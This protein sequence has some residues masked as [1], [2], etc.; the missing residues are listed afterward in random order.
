MFSMFTEDIVSIIAPAYNHEE[1]II[2]SLS[3]IAQQTYFNKQLIVIDDCSSDKTAELI[4]QYIDRDVVR[5]LFPAGIQFIK[6]ERNMNAHYT[7]NEGISM[8][9]GKYI[10]IINTDDCYEKERLSLMIG[11]LKKNNA[12]MAFSNVKCID[13]NGKCFEHEPFEIMA[14]NIYKYP[15]PS[16]ALPIQNV[17]VGTGNFVFEKALFDEVGG[18]S[19]EYHFI[20]DWDFIL[21]VALIS[22]PVHVKDTNYLYRFHSSNTIKQIDESRENT[23]KKDNEVKMVLL[24]F[25][26]AIRDGRTQNPVFDDVTVW[27]Y[28]FELVSDQ[29]CGFLWKQLKEEKYGV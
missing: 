7:I 10:S 19:S 15:T 5:E 20:H 18:F 21:K 29:Y 8:A 12:R 11:E 27:D 25:L 6:H 24:D 2:D 14:R 22:E 16:F 17:A 13:E 28:F 1:Y 4:E 23:I 9:V 3:S 26:S